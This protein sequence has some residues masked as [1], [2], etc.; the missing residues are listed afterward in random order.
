MDLSVPNYDGKIQE[1]F[2]LGGSKSLVFRE[3]LGNGIFCGNLPSAVNQRNRK[4]S[5][6]LRVDIFRSKIQIIVRDRNLLCET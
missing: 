5:D 4:L 1:F 3:T 2:V 6:M